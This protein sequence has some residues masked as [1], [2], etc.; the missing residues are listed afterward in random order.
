MGLEFLQAGAPGLTAGMACCSITTVAGE[1]VLQMVGAAFPPS[2]Q[3]I[4][5]AMRR[6]VKVV[7]CLM[8][9][10][11]EEISYCLVYADCPSVKPKCS[12][13]F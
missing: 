5:K 2:V 12:F 3:G 1:N 8:V 9:P 10:S 11:P 4:E 6:A 13:L 7:P